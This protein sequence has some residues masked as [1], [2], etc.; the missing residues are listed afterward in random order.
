MVA[1]GDF[2]P[3]GGEVGVCGVGDQ[4]RCWPVSEGE[5]GQG[6]EIGGELEEMSPAD[7]RGR[8]GEGE[9]GEHACGRRGEGG[10]EIP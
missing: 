2:A 6:V 9:V 4:G 1:V 5:M 10:G 8:I 3:R 7:R